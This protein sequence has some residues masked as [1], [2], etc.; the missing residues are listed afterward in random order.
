MQSKDNHAL[1]R[2]IGRLILI[3]GLVT[4]AVN[5]LSKL[6]L[7]PGGVGLLVLGILVIYLVRIG[8]S[9]W[10]AQTMCWGLLCVS[11]MG[12]VVNSGIQSISWVA[13]PIAAILGGWLLGKRSAYLLV[14]AG[15]LC[16]LTIFLLQVNGYRFGVM[17][18]PVVT[19]FTLITATV[20]SLL[21]GMA[22]A[23][24]VARQIRRLSES[25]AALAHAQA[26]AG[27]GSWSMDLSTHQSAW[28]TE[29]YRIFGLEPGTP[30]DRQLFLNYVHPDDLASVE[31]CWEAVARGEPTYENT[32]RINVGQQLKWIRDVTEFVYDESGRLVSMFGAQQDI[33]KQKEAQSKIEFLAHHDVLTGLPN[34]LMGVGRL[35][36]AVAA[37]ARHK[38]HV[39]VLY[40]DLDD[41][42]Y[43]NDRYGHGMGD[44]LLQ[45][46]SERLRACLRAEDTLCRLSGDEFMIILPR[47]DSDRMISNAC[48]RVVGDLLS[49][50]NIDGVQVLCSVSIGVAIYPQN[51]NDD[52]TLMR[53]A[54]T[55]LYEAKKQQQKGCYR[56]FEQ[57]M[58]TTLVQY[59]ETRDALRLALGRQEFELHY[60]PQVDLRTG[61]LNG[62]EALVRWHHPQRGLL[63]PT[64][65]ISVVETAGLIVPLGRWVLS[66][67]CRQAAKWHSQGLKFKSLAV[68]LSALQFSQ[69][70]V[71]QDVFT[72][73]RQSGL[74]PSMLE[75]E[76][77]EST[78]LQYDHSVLDAVAHWQNLGIRLA[79]DDF[80]TGY[81]NLSHLK[82]L[83]ADKLKIDR[84]FVTGLQHDQQDQ[85]IVQSIIQIGHSLGLQ[86]LAEGVEDPAVAA[87]LV[88]LGC[89]S[90]Q[91]YYFGRPMSAAQFEV[92]MQDADFKPSNSLHALTLNG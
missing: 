29:A 30:V 4:T 84:S 68:N 63:L 81:S 47:I 36:Q 71:E 27:V 65:F 75:L 2:S 52:E 14:A 9:T 32:Y 44:L 24:S 19:V 33:T 20:I 25:E 88:R 89:D 3:T 22:A 12:A 60:Q 23:D 69:G 1:L 90:A 38:N 10:A 59:L 67:A 11:L 43:V 51:G 37:A 73:L 66:E 49:P 42:K 41:F 77:T 61:R 31:A 91:G 26:L 48:E 50:F 18:P 35:Q 55:A 80:G 82:R 13:L 86:T 56:F 40:L 70:H 78:L 79:I 5:L 6:G 64:D 8:R 76:L 92:W 74:P 15:I 39:A 87:Q 16:L 58:N 34:R 17:V 85:A 57:H 83:N 21:T 62:V 46:V 72:A 53:N 54:D 7:R 28:S 45:S